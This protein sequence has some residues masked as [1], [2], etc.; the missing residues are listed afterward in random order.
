M[1]IAYITA[2]VV[3]VLAFGVW[4]VYTQQSAPAAIPGPETAPIT[5][6]YYDPAR[7]QGPGGAQCTEA[8]LV[9]VERALPRTH[10]PLAD[11][12]R[13]LLRGEISEEERARGITTEFPLEG[14]ELTGA[15]IVDGVATLTF[16]DPRN[17]TIGGSCRVA[18]LR[19]QLEATAKQFASVSEVRILPA[20]LFQP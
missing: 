19:A 17:Q 20:D 3:A 12:V 15:S 14:L 4:Y 2:A 16:V 9:A 7:D 6:Y 8:G 10:T 5:L 1:R 11:A 18:I 13:L